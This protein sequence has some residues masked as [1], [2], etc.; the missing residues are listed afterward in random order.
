MAI[1]NP[2]KRPQ[3]DVGQLICDHY[4]ALVRQFENNPEVRQKLLA[5]QTKEK[6]LESMRKIVTANLKLISNLTLMENN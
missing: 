6:A 1:A 2:R 3:S 5:A 4:D